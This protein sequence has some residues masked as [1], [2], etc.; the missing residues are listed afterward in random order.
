MNPFLNQFFIPFLATN[1]KN[2]AQ[3]FFELIRIMKTTILVVI[4]SLIAA[5]YAATDNCYTQ[6]SYRCTGIQPT[7]N[8][9]WAY[10]PANSLWTKLPCGKLF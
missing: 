8:A 4:V 3:A 7:D 10:C 6:T 5:T 1:N 9:F 2:I